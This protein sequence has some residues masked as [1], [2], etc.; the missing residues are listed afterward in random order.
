MR[1]EGTKTM[2]A[3]AWVSAICAVGVVAN[4]PSGGGLALLAIFGVVPAVVLW[5]F[6]SGSPQTLSESI[7]KARE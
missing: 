2:L 3:A 6:W 4:V 1:F 5:L 7:R